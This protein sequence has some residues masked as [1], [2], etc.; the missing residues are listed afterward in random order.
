MI[1]HVHNVKIPDRIKTKFVRLVESRLKGGATIAREA[2]LPGSRDGGDGS[3]FTD[4]PNSLAGILAVVKGSVRSPDDSEGIIQLRLGRQTAVAGKTL[5]S[6]TR[7]GLDRPIGPGR[8]IRNQKKGK[9]YEG[10]A[11]VH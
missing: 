6:R 4:S 1:D 10:G 2:Y 5:F 3:V 8:P 9:S 11:E 7:D